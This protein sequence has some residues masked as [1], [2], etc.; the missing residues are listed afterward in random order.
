MAGMLAVAAFLADCA[1][2]GGKANS[3]IGL[4]AGAPFMLFASVAIL[5]LGVANLKNSS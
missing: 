4:G 5:L 3:G 1:N 2:A